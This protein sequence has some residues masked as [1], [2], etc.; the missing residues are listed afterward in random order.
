MH[1]LPTGHFVR[2]QDVSPHVW[3]FRPL[4][5]LPID[6]LP[7][8][9]GAKHPQ[10]L[11][12][13]NVS[14][15]ANLGI[16]T[17]RCNF[18]GDRLVSLLKKNMCLCALHDVKHIG[19]RFSWLT[20]FLWE[21]CYSLPHLSIFITPNAYSPENSKHEVEQHR[22]YHAKHYT[23]I[24]ILSALRKLKQLR[25]MDS[26]F[27]SAS[28]DKLVLSWSTFTATLL[29]TFRPMFMGWNVYGCVVYG[30]KCLWWGGAKRPWSELSMGWKVY[31]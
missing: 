27:W 3:T 17:I 14:P 11:R 21:G 19:T 25:Q 12:P 28:V 1:L 13:K 24:L 30:A 6:V 2:C 18:V 10:T 26:Y 4:G 29:W 9:L 20:I 7:H 8:G 15:H 5:N 22:T 31:S 23:I 16:I